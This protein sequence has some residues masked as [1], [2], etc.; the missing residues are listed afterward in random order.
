MLKPAV[1]A[2]ELCVW[3]FQ[4]LGVGADAAQD[5]ATEAEVVDLLVCMAKI[6]VD[7]QRKSDI[8]DPYPSVFDPENPKKLAIDPQAKDYPRCSRLLQVMPS[9][10]QM[11]NSKDFSHMKEVM[12]RCD[13]L[14]F[15]LL[16]WIIT[17]NRS[18]IV[19]LP[20]GK[21]V[22]SMNTSHQYLLLSAPP[23]K[24]ELFRETKVKHGSTYAFHGSSI[25]NWHS[26]LRKGLINA[27]GTKYQVNGAAYGS[28]IYLSPHAGTSFGYSRMYD[29][30]GQAV[31]AKAKGGK[32]EGNRF[33]NSGSMGCI[34]LCEV[35][36]KDIRKSGDIWVQPNPDFVVTRF[37]FVYTSNITNPGQTAQNNHTQNNKKFV[38]EIEAAIRYYQN[39]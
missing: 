19:Q 23:E 26:I 18:H 11:V 6:A 10:E 1:C 21:G 37:F 3:S 38:E 36:N 20:P 34:A 2:R 32:E 33:L 8:F 13:K 29:Y 22:E 31:A 12:D 16:Q 17:S 15:P 30:S 9:V 7:H 24:E 27:S 14:C 39:F 28:G 35:I 4:Q 25:E 5:I